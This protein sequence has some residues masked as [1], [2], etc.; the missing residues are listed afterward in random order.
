MCRL[1]LIAVTAL[2][3]AF[4][5][6]AQTG[7]AY[8]G[9]VA[10][11]DVYVRSGPDRSWYPVM[12]LSAPTRVQVVGQEGEWLKITP[13]PGAFS[14]I[15]KLHVKREGDLGTVTGDQVVV[16]AGS[17]L[18]PTKADFVQGKFS[19]GATVGIVG[20]TEEYYKINPVNA[21][22]YI[23]AAY[24]QPVSDGA[25]TSTRPAIATTRP[26]ATAPA[27]AARPTTTAPA[28]ATAP[29]AA[30]PM[31]DAT[32]APP[33]VKAAFDAAE[34]ALQA[35]YKKPAEKRD[36]AALVATYQAIAVEEDSPFKP[37]IEYRVKCLDWEIAKA[38]GT[39]AADEIQRQASN[40]Q[41]EMTARIEQARKAGGP[42]S[43]TPQPLVVT[44]EGR[45]MPSTLYTNRGFYPKRWTLRV[46]NTGA[47]QAYLEQSGSVRLA[48]F[49]GWK[50][51]VTGRPR[52]NA[53][54][55]THIIEV[56]RVEKLAGGEPAS[57]PPVPTTMPEIP[58][59]VEPPADWSFP[60]PAATQP[61]QQVN[62]E[63]FN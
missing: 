36:Y 27:A 14:L 55:K 6:L 33:G 49:E 57:A 56:T 34:Q 20:E 24:V 52:Y 10:G 38:G 50:V 1:L 13:P 63:E 29:P 9:E 7:T 40:E 39:A 60:G 4:P 31:P 54:L 42:L 44:L 51:K 8:T 18:H 30:P 32:K 45:L 28:V 41:R 21:V 12:Q 26:A 53:A 17:L 62:P 23:Y 2:T 35:E 47:I 22:L 48:D 11:Q 19:R 5:A 25:G 16:R 37:Y 3:L 58:T 43:T 15:S 59:L 61:A 46:D